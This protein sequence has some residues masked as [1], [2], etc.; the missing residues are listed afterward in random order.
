MLVINDQKW[1]KSRIARIDWD[2]TREEMEIKLKRKVTENDVKA[3]KNSRQAGKNYVDYGLCSQR[4]STPLKQWNKEAQDEGICTPVEHNRSD[5]PNQKKNFKELSDLLR[6]IKCL[7]WL[8]DED[9]NYVS[10]ISYFEDDTS[11]ASR[12]QKDNVWHSYRTFLSFQRNKNLLQ[13][14][15]CHGD[16]FNSKRKGRKIVFSFSHMLFK[17]VREGLIAYMREGIE[18]CEEKLPL[19]KATNDRIYDLYS[20]T[21]S[22]L[23]DLVVQTWKDAETY[24]DPYVGFPMKRSKPNMDHTGYVQP[25]LHMIILLTKEFNI[26]SVGLLGICLAWIQDPGSAY[27]MCAAG[28]ILLNRKNMHS[29]FLS[30]IDADP[31]L[32]SFFFVMLTDRVIEESDQKKYS[33]IWRLTTYVSRLYVDQDTGKVV[34]PRERCRIHFGKDFNKWKDDV[35]YLFFVC[36]Y[37]SHLFKEAPIQ[38]DRHTVGSKVTDLLSDKMGSC[39]RL[40]VGHFITLL[41]IL[42]FLP[43]HFKDCK[44]ADTASK[45]IKYFDHKCQ[46]DSGLPE[47]QSKSLGII[48]SQQELDAFMKRASISL[49]KKTKKQVTEGRMEQVLCKLFQEHVSNKRY[50][51]LYLPNQVFVKTD[52][53]IDPN[54]RIELLMPTGETLPLET[55]SL[56]GEQIPFNDGYVTFDTIVNQLASNSVFPEKSFLKTSAKTLAKL[57]DS[58]YINHLKS[59]TAFQS[60]CE[61]E[62][63][64]TFSEV[65]ENKI[66][67]IDFQDGIADESA[68]SILTDTIGRV[69]KLYHQKCPVE[70]L[71]RFDVSK[72]PWKKREKSDTS[73]PTSSNSKKRKR[74]NIPEDWKTNPNFDF[75]T[76]TIPELKELLKQNDEK[77]GGRKPELVARCRSVLSFLDGYSTDEE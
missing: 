73:E 47:S 21:P 58:T 72:L 75:N 10:P 46:L 6:E 68:F 44:R 69:K 30:I 49:T 76:L 62:N 14:C 60:L 23:L 65:R 38:K 53:L 42:G 41:T 59:N 28:A 51:K 74:P 15:G 7:K 45:Q 29:D 20:N 56:F 48:E 5:E 52:D 63:G 57:I 34:M 40:V 54:N 35:N 8:T 77:V 61:A 67:T 9:G 64:C 33:D 18:I 24:Q 22:Y 50:Y 32:F 17:G 13:L 55:P 16:R 2:K 71:V 37:V 70:E 25:V 11:A 39:G 66:P 19:Y 4:N 43:M 12:L 3:D 27:Y 26:N 36:A 1:L 31:Y